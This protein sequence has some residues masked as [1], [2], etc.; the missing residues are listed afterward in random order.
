MDYI[1]NLTRFVGSFN[2]GIISAFAVSEN[3]FN[4]FKSVVRCL[5]FLLLC[6]GCGVQGQGQGCV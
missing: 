2:E 5:F 6:N 1:T 3:Q 4:S